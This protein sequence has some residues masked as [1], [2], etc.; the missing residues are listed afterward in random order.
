MGGGVGVFYLSDTLALEVVRD[1]RLPSPLGTGSGSGFNCKFNTI[2]RD[3]CS[4]H[5]K[6]C[7]PLRRVGRGK[8][9]AEYFRPYGRL[10]VTLMSTIPHT[11]LEVG[12]LEE[13]CR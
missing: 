8:C 10:E 1:V 2:V 3:I 11:S 5:V 4:R 13:L 6:P 7:L 12:I 9:R